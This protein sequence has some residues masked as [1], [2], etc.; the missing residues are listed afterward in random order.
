M[1]LKRYSL[2]DL[3]R[4]TLSINFQIVVAKSDFS[5][6]P[7]RLQIQVIIFHW[8][9]TVLPL[10]ALKHVEYF[11]R[12]NLESKRYFAMFSKIIFV[13]SVLLILS[14]AFTSPTVTGHAIKSS[15]LLLS[16][17][18]NKDQSSSSSSTTAPTAVVRC[19]DCDLCDGSGRYAMEFISLYPIQ[20]CF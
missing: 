11:L 18:E 2:L 10:V 17:R 4:E 3:V 15:V 9:W 16:E 6:P 8:T 7:P 14:S 12:W 1:C 5:N 20:E 19:P 13:L